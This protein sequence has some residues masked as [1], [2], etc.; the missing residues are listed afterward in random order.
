MYLSSS[1]LSF[2]TELPIPVWFC[3]LPLTTTDRLV[4][5]LTLNLQ[6]ALH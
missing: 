1:A 6:Y 2:N 3:I 4:Y 5:F